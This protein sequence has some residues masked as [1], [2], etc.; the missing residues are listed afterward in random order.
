MSNHKNVTD[1]EEFTT[2]LSG[3]GSKLVVVDYNATWCGPCLKIAPVFVQLAHKFPEAL[4]LGV[5][6]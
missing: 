6:G 1:D 2:L 4:F 5:S 3:A